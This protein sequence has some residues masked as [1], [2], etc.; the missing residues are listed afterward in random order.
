MNA[1]NLPIEC[2]LKMNNSYKIEKP[3]YP[4]SWEIP[5]GHYYR[6][7]NKSARYCVIIPV[8]NE[9]DRIR[10]QLK[11][12][13]TTGQTKN[14]DI[15]IVDGDSTDGSID[16]SLCMSSDIRTLIIKKDTGRLGAQLRLGYAYALYEGYEGIVTIDGNGK[17]SIESIPLFLRALADGYD[18][19]Q[20]SRFIP[21]GRG[22][23][24]PFIRKMAIKLIHA[25]LISLAAGK[26]FT[27][28][29]Q[30]FRA[31]SAKYLLHHKVQPFRD[32]FRTYELLAYLSARAS[33]LNLMV[34]E[35][36]TVRRYPKNSPMPTKINWFG[37]NFELI[38]ILVQLLLGRFNPEINEG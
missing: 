8:I 38:K 30:G 21:G 12:M 37:G 22:I 28:T 4:N 27:D 34:K 11:D 36:P 23:N 25:P 17:D 7:K 16:E 15:I 35:I 24:T 32:I 10:Q 14:A 31:Y 1:L 3:S 13:V 9:G 2:I 20:A 19:A 29:T 6:F 5:E 18:Y 33:Q 26:R